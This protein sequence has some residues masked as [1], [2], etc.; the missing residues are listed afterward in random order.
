MDNLTDLQ[1]SDIIY[2]LTLKVK[3]KNREK[4]IKTGFKKIK[5]ERLLNYWK[6][7]INISPEYKE[8]SNRVYQEYQSHNQN[9]VS[10]FEMPSAVDMAKNLTKSMAVWAKSGLK[11]VS[12]AVYD[13]RSDICKKCEFWDYKQFGG[14]CLKCGCATQFKLRLSHERCPLNKWMPDLSS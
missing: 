11:V 9:L 13:H 5:K 6:N 1:L 4:W 2:A 8:L 7:K 10:S 12:S 3:S 14:R